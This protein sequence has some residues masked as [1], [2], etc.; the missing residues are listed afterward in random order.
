MVLNTR[1]WAE[2]KS[3]YYI[4]IPDIMSEELTDME[5]DGSDGEGS[6]GLTTTH[7]SIA[8]VNDQEEETEDLELTVIR[9]R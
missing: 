4:S 7:H 9:L 5:V 2:E 6:S 8:S 1:G 3:S